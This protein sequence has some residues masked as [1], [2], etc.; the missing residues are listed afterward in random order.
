MFNMREL[1]FGDELGGE[2]A[3]MNFKHL[4]TE[5][6]LDSKD[7]LGVDKIE[8]NIDLENEQENEQRNNTRPNTNESERMNKAP[9]TSLKPISQSVQ[10]STQQVSNANNERSSKNKISIANKFTKKALAKQKD[11]VDELNFEAPV[12]QNTEEDL[13]LEVL[14]I[15]NNEKVFCLSDL[16]IP[17]NKKLLRRIEKYNAMLLNNDNKA[18]DEGDKEHQDKEK[19]DKEELENL[20]QKAKNVQKFIKVNYTYNEKFFDKTFFLENY[21]EN[22]SHFISTDPA[23]AAN[24]VLLDQSKQLQQ[25]QPNQQSQFSQQNQ[26]SF[27]QNVNNIS[28]INGLRNLD[29]N[30]SNKE[31]LLNEVMERDSPNSLLRIYHNEYR[32]S[33]INP[34][35]SIFYNTKHFKNTFNHVIHDSVICHSFQPIQQ[36]NKLF[37]NNFIVFPNKNDL[38]DEETLLA[39]MNFKTHC[40]AKDLEMLQYYEKRMLQSLNQIAEQVESLEEYKGSAFADFEEKIGD[41]LAKSRFERSA[42][43]NQF[44]KENYEE[45]LAKDEDFDDNDDGEVGGEG[46]KNKVL[47]GCDS[48]LLLN[49][50]LFPKVS[51][52]NPMDSYAFNEDSPGQAS[53]PKSNLIL[54][55]KNTFNLF[56]LNQT[57]IRFRSAFN[58][59]IQR[60]E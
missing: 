22:T 39:P 13:K 50:N 40:G 57:S 29:Y 3:G 26:F 27:H 20:V 38:F 21:N 6:G 18:H 48:T 33:N 52:T 59:G 10:F 8:G 28:N 60:E 14:A 5:I 42:I 9:Q 54:F 12:T 31:L 34:Y 55:I 30:D 15:E 25:Q 45:A 24:T 32:K 7:L 35:F 36:K 56:S 53:E 16:I 43:E 51:Q 44:K 49:K 23:N 41:R 2:M 58:Q 19:Q 17:T 46:G 4:I 37:N 11:E 47:D 1:L